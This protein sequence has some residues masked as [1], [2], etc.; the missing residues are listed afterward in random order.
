MQ[1]HDTPAD[2]GPEGSPADPVGRVRKKDIE[3]SPDKPP[4]VPILEANIPPELAVRPIWC[5]WRWERRPGRGGKPAKWTKP[6]VNPAGRKIDITRSENLVPLAD[7]LAAVTTGKADGVGVGLEV[8][9]LL[10]VDWDDCRDAA[11]AAVDSGPLAE[12]RALDTYTEASPS[13]TGIKALVVA[14][15][16]GPD[17]RA[18][19][20]EMYDRKRYF[21][22]TGHLL[23]GFPPTPQPRQGE[24]DRLY[25]AMFPPKPCKKERARA[26]GPA[27]GGGAA[28]PDDGRLLAR[29]RR[30]KQGDKFAALFDRGDTS[31]YGGDASDAD[32]ALC[33]ILVWWCQGDAARVDRLFRRSKLLRDKWD[34][35]HRA[36]GATYGRMTVER[37]VEFVGGGY[38]P[39]HRANATVTGVTAT[40]AGRCGGRTPDGEPPVIV[41]GTDE[42]RVSD[43]AARALAREPDLFQRGGQLVRVV[44]HRPEDGGGAAGAVRRP[45]GAPVI[46]PET[47]A[48]IRG[49]LSRAARFVRRVETK[50]GPEDKPAH[51]PG[52][53]VPAVADRGDWPGVPRLEAVVTHPV[54]LPDGSVL[55]GPGFDPGTGL[56]L[57]LPPGL[58]VDVPDRP[59]QA[60]AEAARDLLLGVV[61]DF[62]FGSDAHRAA[63][64]AGLLTPL[65]WWAFDG[66]APLF[67]TDANVRAAGKGLLNDVTALTVFGHRFPVMAYTPDRDELRKRITSLAAEGERAVLLDNLA[68]PIGNDVLD[69]ALT[70]DTWKDRLLGAN[71]VFHGPLHVVWYATGNNV[72]LGADTSRR[73]CHTRLESDRERPEERGDVRHPDLRA[74]VRANRP[75]LLSAALTVLRGWVVAGR[76]TR[77]LPAWGSYE[78]WSAVVRQCVVWAGMA[79]P[80]ETRRV[81]QIDADRDAAAMAGLLAQLRDL[82]PGRAGRTAAELVELAKAGSDLR[83]CVEDLCGR[84]DARVLGNRLRH[85]RRRVFGGWFLDRA[86]TAHQA[87]RWAAFPAGRFRSGP[88]HPP[89]TP[90]TPAGPDPAPGE[91]GET[92]EPVPAGPTPA[93][94]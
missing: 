94:H 15:K 64:F 47:P 76:P 57:W 89:R 10:G 34:E 66:P 91:C 56:L 14:T 85:F 18:G 80:G 83:G 21:T 39:D 72:Q 82:D 54:L 2:P 4:P 12:A 59:T 29:I 75:R 25:A 22:V 78:G 63:W 65:A 55:S 32:A 50:D 28:E 71:R 23:A 9:G 5:C 40:P 19:D 79:D 7:A 84:L 88:G 61:S 92:G 74:H 86:G 43:Q 93:A 60:E 36:D 13:L 6:P 24:V 68:G 81:I 16:P 49:R 3:A 70:S 27:A 17:C 69:A 77:D 41:L 58:A 20:R 8:A 67:L 37:A 30:S 33:S 62:P 42:Y 45:P 87:A 48:L 44:A 38:D 26:A 53:A 90:H 73:V 11:T 51:P 35:K 31:A 1:P 46:R 52:Y